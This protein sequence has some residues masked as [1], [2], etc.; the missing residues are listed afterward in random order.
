M[1]IY[2]RYPLK[3][4]QEVEP[5]PPIQNT[6]NP[7]TTEAAMYADQANQLQ[8]YG[9]LVDGVGAFTYLGTVA[10]TAADYEGFGG[11]AQS[12]WAEADSNKPSF[13]LNKPGDE[14]KIPFITRWNVVA[15]QTVVLPVGTQ[16]INDIVVDWG[17]GTLNRQHSHTYIT[18]GDKLISITG[19]LEDF[20][21]DETKVSS[22]NLIEIVQWGD[23]VWKRIKFRHCENLT[24]IGDDSPN[25]LNCNSLAYLFN[26]TGITIAKAATFKFVQNVTN[27][28]ALLATSP[29]NTIEVGAF[30]NFISLV[31]GDSMLRD[32]KLITLPAK[33]YK[34]CSDLTSLRGFLWDTSTFTTIEEDTFVGL[35]SL[36]DL[37]AAFRETAIGTVPK[38]LLWSCS[39]LIDVSQMLYGT[40]VSSLDKDLFIYSPKIVSFVKMCTNTPTFTVPLPAFWMDFPNADGS[41]FSNKA[42][43]NQSEMPTEWGGTNTD[44]ATNKGTVT[45]T[46]MGTQYAYDNVLPQTWKDDTTVLKFII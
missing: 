40:Q 8:G 22:L 3:V 35:I 33:L 38:K 25:F 39:E 32:T 5:F 2:S 1:G 17:D 37:S 36:R 26:Y 44:W 21:F 24:L 4:M 18:A 19:R 6:G 23:I 42:F 34:N 46:W 31:D 28:T 10:G 13:I 20:Q 11:T 16:G 30:D 7:Y 12:D 41:E 14:G 27:A 45:R 15:N 9:Y 29:F 43:S